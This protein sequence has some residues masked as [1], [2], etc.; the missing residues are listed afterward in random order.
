MVPTPGRARGWP[1]DGSA[2][3]PPRRPRGPDRRRSPPGPVRDWRPGPGARARRRGG[4]AGGAG[5][6]ALGPLLDGGRE[7]DRWARACVIPLKDS[8]P[9]A[10]R[11]LVTLALIPVT[12]AVYF[13]AQPHPN[14]T[15]DPNGQSELRFTYERAA[16]PCEVA[17]Q[18]PLTID[19]I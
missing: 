17:R 4:D 11:A 19:E 15:V 14:R 18:R 2:C 10:G 6:L 16:I 7:R 3:Q 12:V 13:L 1:P 5:L 8:H 9:T